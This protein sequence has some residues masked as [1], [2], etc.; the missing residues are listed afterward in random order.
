MS[1][2]HN[3]RYVFLTTKYSTVFPKVKPKSILLFIYY[4][5]NIL[6]LKLQKP[7]ELALQHYCTMFQEPWSILAILLGPFV[8]LAP[9]D[10]HVIWLSNI[11]AVALYMI[12]TFVS[13]SQKF[14]FVPALHIFCTVFT[15]YTFS[16]KS[17]KHAVC[18]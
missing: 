3:K 10:L 15:S 13:F 8:F 14:K 1:L 2:C 18:T 11:L 17:I 12:S 4:Y 5:Y 7:W 9:E 16:L 6:L